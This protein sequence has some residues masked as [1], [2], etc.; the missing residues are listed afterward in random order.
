[1][2]EN[3]QSTAMAITNRRRMGS[4]PA[5]LFAAFADPERLRLWWGPNGFTNT[6]HA[7]EFR[8]G[9]EWRFTMHAPDGSN[10]ENTCTFGDIVPDRKI[11]FV[12][13]LP[14]HVFTMTMTFDRLAEGSQLTWHM[15]FEPNETNAAVRPFIEAA[16]EQNFDRLEA[17]LK[18][19]GA[20]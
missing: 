1:M 6:I 16:N 8:P 11:V 2:T 12:H 18:T 15:D 17:N 20:E 9:G 13:H 4:T 19:H 5:E 10:F 7:F 3:S 14:M